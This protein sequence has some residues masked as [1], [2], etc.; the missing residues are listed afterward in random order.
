MNGRKR[1]VNERR[2]R[3]GP[4][5]EFVFYLKAQEIGREMGEREKTNS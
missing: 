5:T 2:R 1:S 3:G 4:I